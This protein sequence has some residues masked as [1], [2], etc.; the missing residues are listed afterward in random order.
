MS[1]II[2]AKLKMHVNIV[3]CICISYVLQILPLIVQII[4]VE[5]FLNVPVDF[6]LFFTA[7]WSLFPEYRRVTI[8][9]RP[10]RNI[11]I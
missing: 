5:Y 11:I 1:L 3:P 2:G 10:R 9:Y 7:V 6:L 8:L 4:C